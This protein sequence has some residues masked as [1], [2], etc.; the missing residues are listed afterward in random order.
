MAKK[1][2]VIIKAPGHKPY[3]AAI[4]PTA[5]SIR[6]RIGGDFKIFRFA[7]DVCIICAKKESGL[8]YNC[9]W[10]GR[11]FYGLM[12]WVGYSENGLRPFPD[13]FRVFKA[14]NPSLFEEFERGEEERRRRIGQITGLGICTG[15]WGWLGYEFIRQIIEIL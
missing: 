2:K 7:G 6:R 15:L 12:I 9:E 8:D 4:N 1:I 3:G 14:L 5:A 13:E 11:D 10:A